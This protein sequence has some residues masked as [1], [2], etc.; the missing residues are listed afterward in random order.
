M[1][2]AWLNTERLPEKRTQD[3]QQLVDKW[4]AATGEFSG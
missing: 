4:I 3:Y 1:H 2:R